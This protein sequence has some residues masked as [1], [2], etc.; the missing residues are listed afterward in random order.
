MYS[1]L[2]QM[3]LLVAMMLIGFVAAKLGVTGPAFNKSA[4]PVVMIIF[5]SFTVFNAIMKSSIDF[6]ILKVAE[7]SFYQ[8]LVYLMSFV[9]G[10]IVSKLLGLKDDEFRVTLFIS[11]LSNTVFVAFPLVSAI[12]G[13]TGLFYAS[14][15][16][17]PYNILAFTIGIAIISGDKKN[18]SIKSMLSPPLVVT[19]LSLLILLLKIPIPEFI[20]QLSGTMASATVPLSMVVIGTS[21]AAVP[22]KKAISDWRVYVISFV[23][24]LLIPTLTFFI[25]KALCRDPVIV[26]TV[27]ILSSAPAAILV[28]IF[29]IN[30]NKNE[31]F[32]SKNVFISTV[33]SAV[34]MPLIISLWLN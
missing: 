21:L 2:S 32:A 19:V 30:F 7:L 16:N 8:F 29:S 17:I 4:S 22:V 23:R 13:N 28:N 31:D 20:M 14:I 12:Y 33:L 10:Y 11:L 18:M 6:S 9:L 24:L 1:N 5:L 15:T 3:G 25:M 34:T 26:G 27:V